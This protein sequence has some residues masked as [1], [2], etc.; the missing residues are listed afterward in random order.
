MWRS[1]HEEE[2]K[3]K[4]QL[5][6]IHVG[7]WKPIPKFNIAHEKWWL[8][9]FPIGKVTF[10]GA[11][12]LLNFGRVSWLHLSLRIL[13]RFFDTFVLI[14]SWEMKMIKGVLGS[15]P[16]RNP[17]AMCLANTCSYKHRSRNQNA[18]KKS[19]KPSK[20]NVFKSSTLN[21]P[22]NFALPTSGI[23]VFWGMIA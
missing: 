19:N 14:K 1:E 10:Q 7:V 9:D 8:E 23:T 15:I 18:T 11:N 5:E 3:L 12:E 13:L 22:K 21:L 16:T 4:V 20:M 2:T 17:H 6:T